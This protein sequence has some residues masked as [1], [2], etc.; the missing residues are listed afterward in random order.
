MV[1]DRS[2]LLFV[3]ACLVLAV[4]LTCA[5]G[6]IVKSRRGGAVVFTNTASAPNLSPARR[7]GNVQNAAS[8][9]LEQRRKA[10]EPVLHKMARRNRLNPALV[11]AVVEVE[12]GYNVNARS[13][14]GAIGLMQLMP[15]TARQYGVKNPY[16]AEENLSGGCRYLR[17][18]LD[19][20]DD[21]V[22]LALAA[23]NAGPAAVDKYGGIPAYPETR[24][25][26]RR[27]RERL[28][29]QREGRNQIAMGRPVRMTR[30]ADGSLR[31]VN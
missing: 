31:L 25:Y 11:R 21:D 30:D 29:D 12:S 18:L 3:F 5:E 4:S 15:A 17:A 27:V 16:V 24:E 26:I 23:Y 6:T 19:R 20:Y 7:S 14:K 22:N 13:P 1:G 2:R 8:R 10:I 9:S 28:E